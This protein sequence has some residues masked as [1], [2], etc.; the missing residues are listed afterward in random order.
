VI[1]RFLPGIFVTLEDIRSKFTYDIIVTYIDAHQ[2]FG[3]IVGLD[4]V[5]AVVKGEVVSRVVRC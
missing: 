1:T 2:H 3:I 4:E 5:E